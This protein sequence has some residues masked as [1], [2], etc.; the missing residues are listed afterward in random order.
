M[1]SWLYQSV[2]EKK[3]LAYSI[4][5][6]LVTQV[7]CGMI[8]IYAGCD[9]E[10]VEEVYN[11]IIKDLERLL[12]KGV[13]ESEVELFKTQ[14]KGSTLIGA[15]DVDNRMTSIGVNEMVFTKYKPVDDII[16]EIDRVSKDS[17]EQFIKQ[18]LRMDRIS[19]IIMGPQ[20]SKQVWFKTKF[21]KA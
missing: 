19:G 2:R 6:T 3:G 4:Y 7:D 20:A 5:S 13:S 8:G 10:K 17:V 18:Y 1:T 15:D 21:K 11:L 9:M 14:A 12:E 16:A